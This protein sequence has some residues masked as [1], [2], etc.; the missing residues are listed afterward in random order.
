MVVGLWFGAGGEGRVRGRKEGKGWERRGEGRV[1][2]VGRVESEGTILF[3][4][5][6]FNY[7]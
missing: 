3:H 5:I 7:R 6:V 1:G 2:R 4:K